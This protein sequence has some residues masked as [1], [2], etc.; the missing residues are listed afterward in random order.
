MAKTKKKKSKKI[1][2]KKLKSKVSIK[3]WVGVYFSDAYDCLKHSCK[4]WAKSGPNFLRYGKNKNKKVV[5]EVYF[6]ENRP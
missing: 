4:I 2:L 6:S 5:K 3:E 1:K